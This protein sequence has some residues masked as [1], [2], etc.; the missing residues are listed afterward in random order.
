MAY[1]PPSRGA[2][3]GQPSINDGAV[4]SASHQVVQ[5]V[6]QPAGHMVPMR[7]A[8]PDPRLRASPMPVARS[9]EVFIGTPAPRTVSRPPGPVARVNTTAGTGRSAGGISAVRQ[10]TPNSTPLRHTPLGSER[11]RSSAPTVRPRPVLE[12]SEPPEYADAPEADYF[13]DRGATEC[14]PA[15]PD[16]SGDPRSCRDV[17]RMISDATTPRSYVSHVQ[18]RPMASSPSEDKLNRMA[19]ACLS[20]MSD[21]GLGSPIQHGRESLRRS[22]RGAGVESPSFDV[23]TAAL[24]KSG[25]ALLSAQ[26]MHSLQGSETPRKAETSGHASSS[27]GLGRIDPRGQES[28]ASAS[29]DHLQRLSDAHLKLL[30]D[31]SRLLQ[32]TKRNQTVVVGWKQAASNRM[33][34]LSCLSRWRPSPKPA[35]DTWLQV[36][37]E[38]SAARLTWEEEKRQLMERL[39]RHVEDS[40]RLQERLYACQQQNERLVQQHESKL[41]HQQQCH[42][43]EKD[44]LISQHVEAMAA[45]HQAVQDAQRARGAES[46]ELR[47]ARAAWASEKEQLLAEHRASLA[48]A[49]ERLRE[50]QA[51]ADLKHKNAEGRCEALENAATQ[52]E[53]RLAESDRRSQ[54]LEVRLKQ[55]EERC[56]GLESQLSASRVEAETAMHR[57][58][59]LAH[60]VNEAWEQRRL[61]FER[62]NDA[63]AELQ[64]YRG[65]HPVDLVRQMLEERREHDATRAELQDLR[66]SLPTAPADSASLAGAAA[67]CEHLET[68]VRRL[69]GTIRHGPPSD[70]LSVLAVRL[71][72]ARS[73]SLAQSEQVVWHAHSVSQRLGWRYIRYAVLHAWQDEVFRGRR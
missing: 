2:Q 18:R 20:E 51:A 68:E 56:A 4:V 15:E 64:A 50:A 8:S 16:T 47:L 43:A 63:T 26:E 35:L 59:V 41:H 38:V 37:E 14:I 32:A 17:S 42:A 65:D 53:Q 58:T 30:G 72:Y 33:L 25:S 1:P 40:S 6:R 71:S 45:S 66:S 3:R 52:A 67:R 31:M 61:A 36:E 19:S 60:E 23:E 9:A 55:E 7:Q 39:R 34:L 24:R 11:S 21:L 28:R 27:T 54:E 48:Q 49:E 5:Q 57:A 62:A 73:R 70:G 69:S 13:S 44:E 46:E 29:Q 10:R 22:W 12:R